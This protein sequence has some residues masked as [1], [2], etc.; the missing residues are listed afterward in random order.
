MVPIYIYS[1]A[2]NLI[3]VVRQQH[4]CSPAAATVVRS[5]MPKDGKDVQRDRDSVKPSERDTALR[6]LV[7]W[8]ISTQLTLAHKISTVPCTLSL[9]TNRF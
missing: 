1:N 2:D 3:E 9:G 6:K 5:E 7:N 4:Q 8:L